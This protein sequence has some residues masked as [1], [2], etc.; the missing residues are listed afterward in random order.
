M[1]EKDASDCKFSLATMKAKVLLVD[2]YPGIGDSLGHALRVEGYDVTLASNGQQALN[3]LRVTGFDLVL[4]DLDMPA[5]NGWEAL[6]QIVTTSLSLPA[7]IITGP[8]GQQ[9][10]AIPKG[11]AAVLEK[12]LDLNV[13]LEAMERVMAETAEA[14]RRRME[15]R[16]CSSAQP[17]DTRPKSL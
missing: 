4:L 1:R 9:G 14:R 3:A 12:P 17:S 16:R 5:L 8:S 6:A 10:P 13:L 15:A 7:I 2:D 11:V